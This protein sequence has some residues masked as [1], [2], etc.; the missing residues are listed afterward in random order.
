MSDD[1]EQSEYR[2]ADSPA[3]F[4]A[5]PVSRIDERGIRNR[6][7]DRFVFDKRKTAPPA[8]TGTPATPNLGWNHLTEPS[9]PPISLSSAAPPSVSAHSHTPTPVPSPRNSP[10]VQS[11]VWRNTEGRA[12]VR[13][14]IWATGRYMSASRD[15]TP[16]PDPSPAQARDF[17]STPSSVSSTPVVPS[18]LRRASQ[19]TRR[20]TPA[21]TAGRPINRTE[22]YLRLNHR[23]DI[24]KAILDWQR[25]RDRANTTAYQFRV[26]LL[27][28]PLLMLDHDAVVGN[29]LLR[30][31]GEVTKAQFVTACFTLLSG[32]L[33]GPADLFP[34]MVRVAVGLAYMPSVSGLMISDVQ[35]L[36]STLK[37]PE[38]ENSPPTDTERNR[39]PLAVFFGTVQ[40]LKPICHRVHSR[41]YRCTNFK[42]R[43]RN[44]VHVAQSTATLHR[45]TKRDAIGANLL[46]S[47][48]VKLH[49]IDL[50]CSHCGDP[51]PESVVD[52]VVTLGREGHLLLQAADKCFVQVITIWLEDE[53]TRSIALGDTVEVIGVPERTLG[54]VSNNRFHPRFGIRLGVVSARKVSGAS[55]AGSNARGRSHALT[56]QSDLYGRGTANI[57]QSILQLQGD[58]LSPYGF[59]QK[60]VDQMFADI[61]PRAIWRKTKLAMLLSLVSA[62][63]DVDEQV[64]PQK[65]P[66]TPRRA[67]HMLFLYSSPIPA[68]NRMLASVPRIRHSHRWVHGCEYKHQALGHADRQG[69]GDVK[70]CPMTG[71]KSGVLMVETDHLRKPNLDEL[72]NALEK[73]DAGLCNEEAGPTSAEVTVWASA[74]LKSGRRSYKAQHEANELSMSLAPAFAPLISK[75]DIILNLRGTATLDNHE[76]LLAQHI[77][78]LCTQEKRIEN[79]ST[80]IWN[81][82]MAR[83]LHIAAN[84]EVKLSSECQ[85]FLRLY[86]SAVRKLLGAGVTESMFATMETLIRIACAHAKL[87]LRDTALVDD[88]LVSIAFVEETMALTR[89]QS[90]MGFKPLP[91]DRSN[92]EKMF[93][94]ERRQKSDWRKFPDDDE[95]VQDSDSDIDSDCDQSKASPAEQAFTR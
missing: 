24:S 58:N 2:G 67:L 79:A 50:V 26:T 87:C 91:N 84:I 65:G 88:G 39:A 54:Q 13:A 70:A 94:E 82:D 36:L 69:D 37:A 40:R 38:E 41:L 63:V 14:P 46:T 55:V 60:L 7:R 4:R 18:S 42:C 11:P 35:E 9:S 10:A 25:V 62:P 85:T 31:L 48:S 51:M 6:L 44:T 1:E 86:F 57:P 47:T 45:V 19:T 12:A 27:I 93:G 15:S 33:G 95:G 22:Q 3:I 34:E 28:D 83:F 68:L 77:L 73:R 76:Y 61:V 90:I 5:T 80:G 43:N 21:T 29:E 66:C 30:G 17:A 71:A 20:D 72:I 52:R 78:S 64:K 56:G 74:M 81:P 49:E 92:I 32:A 53:L 75:F 23:K 16:I 8:T 59:T 89:G